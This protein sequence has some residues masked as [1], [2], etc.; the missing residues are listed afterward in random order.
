MPQPGLRINPTNP[1]MLLCIS[2][3]WNLLYPKFENDPN[4]IKLLVNCIDII[5]I[6]ADKNI[7][8]FLVFKLINA[9]KRNLGNSIVDVG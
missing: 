7:L 8:N 3:V 2:K 4:L 1:I 6:N 5:L 9:Y